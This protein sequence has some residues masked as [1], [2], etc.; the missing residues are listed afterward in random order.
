MLSVGLGPSGIA[1]PHVQIGQAAVKGGEV[2]VRAEEREVGLG[3]RGDATQTL[4]ALGQG[5]LADSSITRG[6]PA[7]PVTRLGSTV[8]STSNGN[9]GVSSGIVCLLAVSAPTG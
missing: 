6:T 2:G 8:S 4:I 9:R 3:R 5:E 7:R 1:K